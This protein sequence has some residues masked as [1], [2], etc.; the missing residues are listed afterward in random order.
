MRV[1]RFREDPFWLDNSAGSGRFVAGRQR[2]EHYGAVVTVP[3]MVHGLGLPYG[4][5]RVAFSVAALG[6]YRIRAVDDRGPASLK[7]TPCVATPADG[8]LLA[9]HRSRDW[10]CRR[11]VSCRA[12]IASWFCNCPRMS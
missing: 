9:I 11:A 1:R 12:S 8:G 5:Y 4:I 3:V 6:Q 10:C 7:R 2:V